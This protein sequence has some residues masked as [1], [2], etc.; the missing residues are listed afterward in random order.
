MT[1]GRCMADEIPL[2]IDG[3][4]VTAPAGATVFQ[5]ARRAG[6]DIP[7]LCYDPALGLEPTSSCRLCVVEVEGARGPVP[8]CSYPAAAGMVVRTD[9][10]RLREVRKM[11]LELL[12]SD[13]PHD[14][15]TCEKSGVCALQKYAY[16]F[17]V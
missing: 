16:D 5:A 1:R 9:S 15:L 6:I 4:S 10:P 2:T 8:S 11:V 17:G 7:H 13:H 12:L 14:C 3:Q